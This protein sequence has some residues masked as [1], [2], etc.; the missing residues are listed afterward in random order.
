MQINH[1]LPISHGLSDNTETYQ[2][3]LKNWLRLLAELCQT[4]IT[5]IPACN[6]TQMKGFDNTE[7]YEELYQMPD[8]VRIYADLHQGSRLSP[9]ELTCILVMQ[10]GRG[11]GCSVA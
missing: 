9:P 6:G 2:T 5:A 4:H 11:K 1:E 8:G 10:K 7:I 3:F